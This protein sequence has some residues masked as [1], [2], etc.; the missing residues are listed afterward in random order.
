MEIVRNELEFKYAVPHEHPMTS[1]NP[2][3]WMI[4]EMTVKHVYDSDSNNTVWRIWI[5]GD[6]SCWFRA[7]QCFISEKEECEHYMEVKGIK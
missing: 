3:P 1:I 2:A 6:G 4:K 7:D 5:R